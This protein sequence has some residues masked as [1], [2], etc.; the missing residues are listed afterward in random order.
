MKNKKMMKKLLLQIGELT[1]AVKA[2]EI[3]MMLKTVPKAPSPGR[4]Y[5][6][7]P[8]PWIQPTAPGDM[9]PRTIS[10]GSI[11]FKRPAPMLWNAQFG[12]TNGISA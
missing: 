4:P 8:L 7:D 12:V 6:G 3:Q 11:S 2:L 5:I 9:W 1:A 10:G